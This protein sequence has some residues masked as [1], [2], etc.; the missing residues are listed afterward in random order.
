M[1]L[2]YLKRGVETEASQENEVH[3]IDRVNMEINLT[4]VTQNKRIKT[5]G[6]SQS[7]PI[8]S[9]KPNPN[10]PRL[11]IDENFIKRAGRVNRKL[12]FNAADNCK[13]RLY[14]LSMNWLRGS[15]GLKR[16]SFWEWITYR[17]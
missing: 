7:I 16:A 17:Q 2:D 5:H 4:D 13:D 12:W 6:N 9:I 8:N 14:R 10:Q 3:E 15:A 1:L 11:E